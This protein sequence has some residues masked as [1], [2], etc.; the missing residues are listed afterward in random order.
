[1]HL[2]EIMDVP[3]RNNGQ[4]EF[5]HSAANLITLVQST[6]LHPNM[7]GNQ[8]AATATY[9]MMVATDASAMAAKAIPTEQRHQQ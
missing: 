7:S 2:S 4:F 6:L 3:I 8:A 1:M 5:D 9:A